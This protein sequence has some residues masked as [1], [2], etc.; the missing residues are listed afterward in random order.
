LGEVAAIRTQLRVADTY[1]PTDVTAM[2][3]YAEE[4]LDAIARKVRE[5]NGGGLA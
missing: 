1:N 5:I 4:H 3:V 2:K